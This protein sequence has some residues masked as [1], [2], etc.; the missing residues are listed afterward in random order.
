MPSVL[1][2]V[3]YTDQVTKSDQKSTVVSCTS[4]FL[5]SWM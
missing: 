4:V 3:K 5:M 2:Y 1:E